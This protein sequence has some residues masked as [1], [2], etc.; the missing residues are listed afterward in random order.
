METLIDILRK[1]ETGNAIALG[2]FL[3][4]FLALVVSV[5][6]LLVAWRAY[7]RFLVQEATKQ[8]LEL[9]LKLVAVLHSTEINLTLI[10]KPNTRSYFTKNLFQFAA[11][12]YPPEKYNWAIFLPHD[13]NFD[14][15]AFE[16]ANNPLLPKSISNAL[17]SYNKHFIIS[18]TRF[19]EL[20]EYVAIGLPQ[21]SGEKSDFTLTGFKGGI[22]QLIKDCQQIRSE[23]VKW[24]KK[25]GVRDVNM[26]IVDREY[27]FP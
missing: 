7:K 4:S 24:L 27:S 3:V 2:S 23:L 5:A 8:Q 19:S 10:T 12:K 14:F 25:H 20:T 11:W 17:I 13:Y 26:A 18:P 9:V 21:Q 16:F 6:T 1:S 15:P 22:K